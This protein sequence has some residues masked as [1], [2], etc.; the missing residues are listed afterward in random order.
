MYN[1]LKCTLFRAYARYEAAHEGRRGNY[2][3]AKLINAVFGLAT[4]TV[5]D[6]KI[7]LN[8]VA[9]IDRSLILGISHDDDVAQQIRAIPQGKSFLDIG[10]NIGYFDLYAAAR[11]TPVFAF[12]PSPREAARLR[13]NVAINNFGNLVTVFEAGI[14]NTSEKRDLRLGKDFNPGQNSVLEVSASA[15]K[16]QCTFAPLGF[17]LSAEQLATVGL[18]KID[19]EGFEYQVIEGMKEVLPSLSCPIVIEITPPFLAKAGHSATALY[20]LFTQ[21]G[22]RPTVG[23]NESAKRGYDEVFV[24]ENI[25]L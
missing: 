1:S 19:V 20:E 5:E 14:S 4:F 25:G 16:V 9:A 3:I 13:Q 12:E 18:I 10:A 23:L 6:F 21:A 7:E 22:Y 17:Y 2:Q 24:K 8:P 15:E 11:G